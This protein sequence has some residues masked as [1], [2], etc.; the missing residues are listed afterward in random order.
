MRKAIRNTLIGLVALPV[1]VYSSAYSGSYL[2]RK[3]L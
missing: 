3:A 2:G 1:L